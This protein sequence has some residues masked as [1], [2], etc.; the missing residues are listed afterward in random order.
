MV[1][2]EGKVEDEDNIVGLDQQVSWSMDKEQLVKI[3]SL[4]GE[5]DRLYMSGQFSSVLIV[6]N[7]CKFCFIQSL[8]GEERSEL[9]TLENN[10][11][12][13]I[14][15]DRLARERWEWESNFKYNARLL[16]LCERAIKTHAF[17]LKGF[18]EDYRIRI[19]DLLNQ[20]GYLMKHKKDLTLL[21]T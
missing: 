8:T 12:L 5:A 13:S 14:L 2:S 7:T 18:V 19:M 17:K 4:L 15:A 20:Y 3:S 21:H 1:E 6:L 11:T 10:M 9:E 16:N